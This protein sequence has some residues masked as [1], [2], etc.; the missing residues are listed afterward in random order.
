[1][2]K[3]LLSLAA[4]KKYLVIDFD[5]TLVRLEINWDGWAAG[6]IKIYDQFGPHDDFDKS[7]INHLLY[8]H[9][10]AK[11]GQP[12]IEQIKI[13]N[14]GYEK[15]HVRG[16]TPDMD[17]ATAIKQLSKSKNLYIY[18]SNARETINRG[19]EELQIKDC[20]KQI[21]AREDV[22]FLKP[23]P[24]GFQLIKDFAQHKDQFLMIGDSDSDREAAQAA[25]IDFLKWGKFE[26]YQF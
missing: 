16:F 17:L 13:F 25:G 3:K 4:K 1:M 22:N 2:I 18:S 6:V 8:N 26:T 10:A 11:H 23:S 21:I 9:M 15:Q 7:H 5:R 12:L 20:F 19:L 14:A 24:E